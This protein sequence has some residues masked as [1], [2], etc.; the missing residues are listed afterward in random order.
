VKKELDVTYLVNGKS[1][2]SLDI[3]MN[4][5]QNWHAT[6]RVEKIVVFGEDIDLKMVSTSYIKRLNLTS[7][8]DNNPISR[9]TIDFSKKEEPFDGQMTL[10]FANFSFCRK[11]RL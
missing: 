7:R 9:K 6:K 8:Q 1:I 2:L 4:L 5:H 10:Y 11:Y 3:T